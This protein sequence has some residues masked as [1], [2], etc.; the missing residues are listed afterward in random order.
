MFARRLRL[1]RGS[2]GAAGRSFRI[3]GA[4]LGGTDLGH[5]EPRSLGG[6]LSGRRATGETPARRLRMS[7]ETGPWTFGV[8]DCRCPSQ[9]HEYRRALSRVV[10]RYRI[11]VRSHA[12]NS[13]LAAFLEALCPRRPYGNHFW[14]ALLFGSS[15]KR[16]ARADG[17]RFSAGC[18]HSRKIGHL[19][20]LCSRG[21]AWTRKIDGFAVAAWLPREIFLT[22]CPAGGLW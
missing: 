17:V 19:S 16:L 9:L 13:K 20:L 18:T 12:R 3:H 1:P 22:A 8:F 6:L 15:S 5:L 4:I 11:I 14:T 7:R 2:P 21:C 10:A